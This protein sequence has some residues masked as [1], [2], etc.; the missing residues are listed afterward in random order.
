M[1][2]G[3]N[4]G[5]VLP[6]TPAERTI[7]RAGAALANKHRRQNAGNTVVACWAND[8]VSWA[9]RPR[10]AGTLS[11][12]I[13]LILERGVDRE[14]AAKFANVATIVA[15]IGQNWRAAT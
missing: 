4:F 5:A 14:Q 11:T 1:Q 8:I 13:E 3:G 12:M 15:T 10:S 2:F 7:C 9:R 6:T